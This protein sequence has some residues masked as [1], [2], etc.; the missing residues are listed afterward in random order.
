L[1][2]IRFRVSPLL[3]GVESE[4]CRWDRPNE[5]SLSLAAPCRCRRRHAKSREPPGLHGKRIA[6]LRRPRGGQETSECSGEVRPQRS[7]CRRCRLPIG[8]WK[9]TKKS[10]A[11]TVG[12][13]WCGPF[14]RW[15]G[16]PPPTITLPRRRRMNTH[17][18]AGP[19]P[20]KPHRIL[21]GKKGA[22]FH[23]L[24]VT[25]DPPAA[26]IQTDLKTI[27]QRYALRL[28]HSRIAALSRCPYKAP[29]R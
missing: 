11:V 25:R 12:G 2:T 3:F 22:G 4:F 18:L 26:A 20:C 8:I 10:R 28:A 7:S 23:T 13:S 15:I 29:P 14:A 16:H 9:A 1:K 27:V 24:A 6:P 19:R 5:A 21:K 17:Q